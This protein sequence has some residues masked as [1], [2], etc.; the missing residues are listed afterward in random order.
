[1]T[2]CPLAVISSMV[3]GLIDVDDVGDAVEAESVSK[4]TRKGKT[5]I[6]FWGDCDIGSAATK[7]HSH[8]GCI[9]VHIHSKGES[10]DSVV[11]SVGNPQGIVFL[12]KGYPLRKIK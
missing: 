5:R 6:T 4:E 1:L 8:I 12:I 10:K 7:G 3:A 2:R 11:S 9:V